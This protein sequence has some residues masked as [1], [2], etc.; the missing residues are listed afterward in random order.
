MMDET[1][2]ASLSIPLT[3]DPTSLEYLANPYPTLRRLQEAGSLHRTAMGWLVTRY[4]QATTVLR[5][6]RSWGSGMTPER[7]LSIYGSG[8]MFEYA[9]RRMNNYNPPEHTRL[10]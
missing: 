7:R 10:R 3:F 6:S 4:E 1:K 8:P 5:E 9:S 2:P